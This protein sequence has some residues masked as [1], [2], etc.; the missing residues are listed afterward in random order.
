MRSTA[1]TRGVSSFVLA[2]G[3][4]FAGTQFS[5]LALTAPPL[6]E[7]ALVFAERPGEMELTGRLIARFAP[8]LDAKSIEQA[9]AAFGDGL[10]ARFPETRE[11][12]VRT[13]QGKTDAQYA[14]E[15]LATGA[16]AYVHPDWRCFPVINPN[17]PSFGS[18][19]H[20]AVMQSA[21]AWDL[22]RGTSTFTI[23]VVDTGINVEHEDLASRRVPG[24]NSVSDLA[25]INGGGIGDVNGHGTAVAGSAAAIGNNATGVCGVGWNFKV[26][27]VRTSDAPGGGAFLS[28][29]LQGLRWAAENGCRTVSA[30]YSGVSAESVGT[31]GTY[32]KSIGGLM[33]YPAGNSGNNWDWFDYPDVIVVGSSNPSDQRSGF[34]GYG[35]AID[36]LAP[37]ES[38]GT[39]TS[40]GGYGSVSGTSFS[41]PI[42]NAA[43][44]MIWSINPAW[45]PDEV[46]NILLTTCTDLYA[47]GD[48]NDSGNGR[49][50]LFAAVQAAAALAG[51]QP[52]GTGDDVFGPIPGGAAFDCDVLANDADI[53]GDAITIQSFSAATANGGTVTLSPVAGPG[54]RPMLRYLPASGFSGTDTFTYTA[55]DSTH[56]A[57]VETSVQIRIIDAGSFRA[58]DSPGFTDAGLDVTYYA[59]QWD[60]LPNFDALTPYAFD[61]TAQ[62]NY[63]STGGVF[64]TSGRAD[65]VGAVYTGFVTVDAP[66]LYTFYTN[67]DDGSR[68]FIG[69]QMVVNND[70][71]HGMVERSG[72]IGLQAGAHALRI[73]FFER[74]GGAGVIASYSAAML[75]KQVIPASALTRP[76][77]PA[78]WNGDSGI[79]DLDIAAFFTSFEAGEADVDGSGGVDD[80]DIVAFF[81]A[82]E[83]GC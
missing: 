69:D 18:Q 78:D 43:L 68:L 24:F 23:G 58:P 11:I 77:C 8:A 64:A 22:W 26:M 14:A 46:Q 9:E 35:L 7:A 25:E 13:P 15:L 83:S 12:V 31:T 19:W 10:L 44:A 71:L 36:L 79:D 48:D 67:S 30:S 49:L 50:N 59:G 76:A 54:G 37:G 5:V 29:I 66:G 60:V 81:T 47:P 27:M 6:A 82:F 55:I 63:P 33:C 80:L 28:D 70:G 73:E 52:P 45:T 57:S 53:N 42:T 21:Q 38:I 32:V 4:A 16:Y 65:D 61:T 17:D 2:A 40:D 39:T 72:T 20:H 3:L 75:P 34:S 74:G 41:T 51:Q 62:V 1:G 56:R